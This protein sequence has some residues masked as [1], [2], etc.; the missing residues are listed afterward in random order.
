[1]T[2]LKIKGSNCWVAA[3]SPDGK[4]VCFVGDFEGN[5]ELYVMDVDG[6]N[7]RNLTR[8]PGSDQWPAWS[9]DGK[10]IAFASTRT[11]EEHLYVV[12]PDGEGL[13]QVTG[14]AA[15]EEPAE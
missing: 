1:M 3:V 13:R 15:A 6:G 12:R 8:H 10:W 4:R 14:L 11:G 9:H 5:N 7:L 2:D